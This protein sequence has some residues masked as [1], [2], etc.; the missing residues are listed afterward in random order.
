MH[1]V[2]RAL[3]QQNVQTPQN[4]EIPKAKMLYTFVD[5]QIYLEKA[6]FL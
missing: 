2:L 1:R 3:A 6:L 4:N 5:T